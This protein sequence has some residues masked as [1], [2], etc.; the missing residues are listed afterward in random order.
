[1]TPISR[2][3]ATGIGFLAI[4]SWALLALL[5]VYS[6]AVPPFQLSAICFAIGGAIGIIAMAVRGVSIGATFRQPLRVWLLGVGGIFG[7]HFFYF[8]ALRNAPPA[9]SNLI[10]NLWPLLIVL[11]SGLLP[12]ERLRPLHIVGAFAALAGA[13]LLVT[14]GGSLAFEWRYA[15]GY[16]AALACALIWSSYSVTSRLVGKVPSDVVAGFCLFA[17]ALAA[18]CHLGLEETVWPRDAV[19]WAAVI[20][21]GIGPVG[22]AFYVWDIGMKHGNIQF[23]GVGSYA[24]PLIATVLL[25]A[26]GIAPPSRELI[27]A[28]LLIVL[29][30]S[31][32]AYASG[33]RPATA[34]VPPA[35]PPTTR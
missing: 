33:R 29:G 24:S 11:F 1:M 30:A 18:L 5:T 16:G 31:L 10:A 9:D 19:E 26:V 13:T 12:G 8:T 34:A 6:G 7:Y 3:L 2:R 35:D 17:A 23:L 14:R 32:A 20:G 21:L 28:A 4:M 22:G 25:I 15:G 27:V